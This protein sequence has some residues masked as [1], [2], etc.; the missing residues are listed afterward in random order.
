[1]E[2]KK[3]WTRWVQQTKEFPKPKYNFTFHLRSVGDYVRTNPIT[4]AE[5]QK[6]KDAAKFWAWYHDKRVSIHKDRVGKGLW[7]VTV[8]LV[9]HH[10]RHIND[11][12]PYSF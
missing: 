5:Y 2:P 8:K 1:M 10:G 7:E 6:I 4:E 3:T 11:E 12:L 9:A